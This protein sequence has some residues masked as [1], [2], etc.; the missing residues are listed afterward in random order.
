MKKIYNIGTVKMTMQSNGYPQG[1]V[2]KREP[3]VREAMYILSK[4]LGFANED[5]KDWFDDELE[6][7]DYRKQCRFI[8]TEYLKGDVDWE[9]L[10]NETQC[11]DCDEMGFPM[12]SA[13]PLAV[14]MKQ[15]GIIE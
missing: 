14:Y 8:L 5:Y 10:C 11:Y 1:F 13:F 9:C 2:L 15:K 7:Q 4:I 12:A 6:R 3:T